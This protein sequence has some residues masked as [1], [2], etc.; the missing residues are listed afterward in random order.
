M[1]IDDSCLLN[2][3]YSAPKEQAAATKQL[4]PDSD[5]S[6]QTFGRRSSPRQNQRSAQLPPR[7][8]HLM[9]FLICVWHDASCKGLYRIEPIIAF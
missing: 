3:N 8:M 1:I 2:Q 5:D 6:L 4:R 9:L 7:R